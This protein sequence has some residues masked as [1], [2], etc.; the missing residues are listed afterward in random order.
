M[1][2]YAGLRPIEDRGCTWGDL[3]D[4]TLH[5]FA[6]KTGR[7]RD[8]DLIGASGARPRRVADGLRPSA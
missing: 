2:A 3:R 6:T 1:L 4:R 8:V 7:A 5:V